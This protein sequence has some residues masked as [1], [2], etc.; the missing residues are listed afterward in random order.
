M[1]KPDTQ[2]VYTLNVNDE[3]LL[4]NNRP[5]VHNDMLL[6]MLSRFSNHQEHNEKVLQVFNGW[7]TKLLGKSLP[8]KAF[9]NSVTDTTFTTWY[10]NYLQ[11]IEVPVQTLGVY[12]NKYVW[13]ND[14]L[15]P[16]GKTEIKSF[17]VRN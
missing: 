2:Y 8:A 15:V 16:A 9:T 5:F 12:A 7:T 13:A 3:P 17:I 10:K 6:V 11:S 14:K 1:N 4:L